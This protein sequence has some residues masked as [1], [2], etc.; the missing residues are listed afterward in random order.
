MLYHNTVK[1]HGLS[2]CCCSFNAVR[3]RWIKRTI[4]IK[5]IKCFAGYNGHMGGERLT[6]AKNYNITFE[7]INW[8]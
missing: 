1:Q 6:S 4:G 2:I 7:I 8:N 5:E 3:I